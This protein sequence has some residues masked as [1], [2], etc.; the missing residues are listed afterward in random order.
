VDIIFFFALFFY[1]FLFFF[2]SFFSDD[3]VLSQRVP[4]GYVSV[5][6]YCN[7][8]LKLE[9]IGVRDN[10]KKALLS[11]FGSASL[12]VPHVPA[13]PLYSFNGA[14]LVSM[15]T[16]STSSSSSSSSSFS[17]SVS[18]STSQSSKSSVSLA[19]PIISFLS[20]FGLVNTAKLLLFIEQNE[21]TLENLLLKYNEP[22]L[23]KCFEI[24]FNEREKA[25]EVYKMKKN[26]FFFFFL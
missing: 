8:Y 14:A 15:S 3:I 11:T 23:A 22:L 7:E 26:M 21:K 10:L 4:V 5:F 1:F 25:L 18:K 2:P 9:D 12:T 13:T 16:T 6:E 24:M 19:T 17:S 20:V